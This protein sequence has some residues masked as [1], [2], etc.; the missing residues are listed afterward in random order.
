MVATTFANNERL[1]KPVPKA[2]RKSWS[3]A[4]PIAQRQG[5]IFIGR[6]IE[7]QERLGY[8][9]AIGFD[10]Q[11]NRRRH[12]LPI[13]I[14]GEQAWGH[15]L[16]NRRALPHCA[17]VEQHGNG[18]GSCTGAGWILKRDLCWRNIKQWGVPGD[19]GGV[20][21]LHLHA[22]EGGGQRIR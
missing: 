14:G 6:P 4:S 21:D 19:S 1:R 2:S 5:F 22:A 11:G 3:E 10:S 18:R 13:R 16:H 17:P 15:L 9:R 8:L 7:L 12:T 20:P